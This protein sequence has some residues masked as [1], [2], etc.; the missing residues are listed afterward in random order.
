MITQHT[1][2]KLF[3]LL[4]Y[5]VGVVVLLYIF[6]YIIFVRPF[7]TTYSSFHQSPIVTLSQISPGYTL[8][9]PYNRVVNANSQ[10]KGKVYLLDLA[11]NPIHTWIT[12]K[13]PLY[14]QLR[15]NGNLLVVMEAP[16][17]NHPLP[18]GG[19]TGTIQ[20]LDWN[21]KVVWEYKNEMM[22][23]DFVD[24][25]NGNILLSLWEKTSPEIASQIKGG[26]AGT[27]LNGS[28]FSDNLVEINK[29]GEIVWSWHSS[30]HLDPNLDIL[31]QDMPEFAWTYTNGLGYTPRNP[32]DGTE[33]FIVSMRS[34]NE[35]LIVRKNDGQIIWRSPQ[36]MLNTQHDPS[37]LANGNILVF[38]NGFARQPNPFPSYGSRVVEINPR[39]NK[40]VWQFD[41]GNGVID[42]VRFFAPIVGGAER[43]P[44]GNTL[45]TDGPKGHIFEVT[46]DKKVVWDFIS[47]Y[48]TEMTGTF[49]NNFLFKSRRYAE[50][51]I[52]WPVKIPTPINT[53]LFSIFQ[54]F[55][56]LYNNG[57]L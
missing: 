10:F 38:D 4:I 2:S 56:P 23:H 32:I 30:E 49:P 5:S 44:N 25:P 24:L 14:S 15:K 29:K 26:V 51:S 54:A 52:K 47:P 3:P 11:G 48:T 46:K 45:I 16:K 36:Q 19:N 7:D 8:I 31:G 53:T 18:P 50:A 57:L 34:L 22:H 21:S 1:T 13:Q 41:G 43:L 12:D 39:T 6:G 27:T 55:R 42:K 9:A 35:V 20:E 40:I 28:I 17:Y 37:F 33:A